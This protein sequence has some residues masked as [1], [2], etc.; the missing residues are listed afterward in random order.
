MLV[1]QVLNDSDWQSLTPTLFRAIDE[2]DTAEVT[3]VRQ[4]ARE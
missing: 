4:N 1:K 3:K 2:C